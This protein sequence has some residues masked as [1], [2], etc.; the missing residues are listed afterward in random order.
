MED[1]LLRRRQRQVARR[2]G[3]SLLGEP[4]HQRH[5]GRGRASQDRGGLLRQQALRTTATLS[6]RTGSPTGWHGS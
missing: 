3:A 1:V 2:R 5:Q 4:L 6:L